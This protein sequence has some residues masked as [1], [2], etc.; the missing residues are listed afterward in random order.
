MSLPSRQGSRCRRR[1]PGADLRRGEVPF[2][3]IRRP[4][5]LGLLGHTLALLLRRAARCAPAHQRGDSVLAIC[6]LRVPQVSGDP[7]DPYFPHAVRTSAR[8]GFS[9]VR[10]CVCGGSHCPCAGKPGTGDP[11]RAAGH[12]CGMPSRPPGG[13]QRGHR[14]TAPSRFSPEGQLR[15]RTSRSI[16]SSA[17]SRRMG[18]LRPLILIQRPVTRRALLVSVDPAVQGASLDFRSGAT[19]RSASPPADQPDRAL[20]EIPVELP[21]CL[22]HRHLPLRRCVHVT[23][24]SP[25]GLFTAGA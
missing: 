10:R 9:A 19:C 22:S 12:P 25:P 5:T 14:A 23:R 4:A 1:T 18:Q 3:Q 2:H 13:D 6:Q 24:G 7:R 21:A 8:P 20:P 15:L 11:Q 16:A 17:F